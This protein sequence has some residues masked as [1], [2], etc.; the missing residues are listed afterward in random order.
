VRI[1]I[2]TRFLLDG[3][4]EGIGV[5]TNE[6]LRRMVESHPE[7]DFFFF[8][9]RPFDGKFVFGDNVTPVVVNPPARHPLLWY[10]WFEWGVPYYLKKL[11]IDHFF[12][13][14]SYL[15]LR[16][17]VPQTV[18]IHD[19]AFE[20]FPEAVGGLVSRF[21][22]YYL[23]RYAKKAKHI[24]TVSNFT[25]N[26]IVVRYN[27]EP[28]D[29]SVT[30]NAADEKFQQLSKKGKEA[31]K[32]KYTE[33]IDY[34]LYVG[35]LHPRKNIG[36]LLQAFDSFKS[37]T[38]SDTKLL[39]VGRKAW[40]NDEM[41]AVYVSMKYQND[42]VFTGRVS[43]EDLVQIYGAAKSL[44]YVPYFEGFG[45]PIV[46]AQACGVP[47]I[48]SD[49]S[50]MP[51]VLGDAGLLVDPFSVDSIANAMQ[52]LDKNAVLRD[53]LVT[54]GNQNLKRFDWQKTADAIFEIISKP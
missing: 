42:V 13:P 11:K 22:F 32:S 28:K 53:D 4:L 9:D 1:A 39:L 21:Y 37:N 35:A 17:R 23:P 10:L 30:Y 24:I 52:A 41:E 18:V 6:V 15:S 27:I 36:R 40:G 3:K 47:V 45:M 54:K 8:F 2:N 33:R 5:F 29:I 25:K 44:V 16:T 12:S 7:V 14:D 31:V 43:D 26:D 20:H 19:L 46:E 49:K 34:Y 38:K 50:S 48:T 51:E